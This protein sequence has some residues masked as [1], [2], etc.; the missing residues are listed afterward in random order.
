[1]PEFL[2]IIDP[3]KP[4]VQSC[5]SLEI[6][7][8]AIFPFDYNEGIEMLKHIGGVFVSVHGNIVWIITVCLID[9]LINVHGKQL[10]QCRNI[11]LLNHTDP[12]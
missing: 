11:Q 8:D 3:D 7:S 5:L 1:M 6:S 12:V 10:R 9:L 2:C 4:D